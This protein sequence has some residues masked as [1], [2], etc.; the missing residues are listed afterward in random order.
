MEIVCLLHTLAI[1]IKNYHTPKRP[2]AQQNIHTAI[3]TASS[4]PRH[5]LRRTRYT[6]ATHLDLT[7]TAPS[8]SGRTGY[9]LELLCPLSLP[10]T[11]LSSRPIECLKL[12]HRHTHLCCQRGKSD[13]AASSDTVQLSECP[14]P[15]SRRFWS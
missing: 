1:G 8:P 6:L 9:T 3:L 13:L 12:S 4:P 10:L 11:T 7:P 14:N 15:S 5:L 2:P